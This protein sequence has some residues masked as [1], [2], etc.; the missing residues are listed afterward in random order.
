MEKNKAS[1]FLP[2]VLVAQ[3][4]LSSKSFSLLFGGEKLLKPSE[5]LMHFS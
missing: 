2:D 1:G 3:F 5:E 4:D